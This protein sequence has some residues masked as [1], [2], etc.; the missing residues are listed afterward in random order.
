[1]PLTAIRNHLASEPRIA[2]RLGQFNFGDG[3]RPGIFTVTPPPAEAP[4]PVITLS[5]TGN[6]PFGDRSHRGSRV[7][8]SIMLFGDKLESDRPL[9]TLAIEVW[10]RLNRSKPIVP[11][12]KVSGMIAAFPVSRPEPE[13]FPA[14]EVIAQLFLREEDA[15]DGR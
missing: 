9:R 10:K 2:A 6:L 13:G 12:F 5:H 15:F 8:I 4:N 7:V 3:V 11:G 14:Y 1:M